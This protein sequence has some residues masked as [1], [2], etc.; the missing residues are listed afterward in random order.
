MSAAQFHLQPP[1][2]K[3]STTVC[4]QTVSQRVL[5]RVRETVICKGR[6][7]DVTGISPISAELCSYAIMQGNE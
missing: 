3:A 5:F 1:R 4:A 7:C 6:I 2:H